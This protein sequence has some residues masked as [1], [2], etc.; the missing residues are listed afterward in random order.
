MYLYVARFIFQCESNI[1]TF[2]KRKMNT[3]IMS[4]VCIM[5]VH[6]SNSQW[7]QSLGWNGAGNPFRKSK[8]ASGKDFCLSL[9]NLRGVIGA[10]KKVN[11]FNPLVT[12]RLSHP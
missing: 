6:L 8:L 2:S 3:T 7:S 12:N 4:L 10:L 5:S 11:N 1:L 9:H